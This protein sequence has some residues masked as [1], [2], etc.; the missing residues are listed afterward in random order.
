[1]SGITRIIRQNDY[2]FTMIPNIAVRDPEISSNAFRLLAYLLSHENG[3][4]L[5][6]NQ[7]ER[8]TDLGR[9]AIKAAI[10]SLEKKGYLKVER[11]RNTDGSYGSYNWIL[12]DPEAG[13][14]ASGDSIV[15]STHTGLTR[16][17]KN[18]NTKED[19]D[20]KKINIEDI[21][22]FDEFWELYPRKRDKGKAKKAYKTACKKTDEQTIIDS[23]K[24]YALEVE[25]KEATYIKYPA[26]WLNAEAWLNEVEETED[27]RREREIRE[28]LEND[29]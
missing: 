29:E 7:I 21:L 16:P 19:K 3:Y 25:G 12:L 8:Q 14:S 18:I 9:Y 11:I 2:Q 28:L 20:N 23:V 5:R 1:M 26:S 15:D 13:E 27:M 6:Y 17:L 22:R 10:Q 4:E 24:Q